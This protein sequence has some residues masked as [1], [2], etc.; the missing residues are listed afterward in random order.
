MDR[1]GSYLCDEFRSVCFAPYYTNAM[2]GNNE[3][4]G[5]V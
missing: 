4:S 3:W 5:S 1:G 2:L